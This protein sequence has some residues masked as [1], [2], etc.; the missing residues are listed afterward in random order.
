[1]ELKEGVM[2]RG[3][4]LEDIAIENILQEANR[5]IHGD[6]NKDYCHPL[7][8]YMATA[9]IWSGILNHKLKEPLTPEE[10]MLCMIGVKLSRESRRHKRDNLVD[11]AGYAGCIEMAIEERERRGL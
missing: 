5:L 7:D 1:M 10:T 2:E 9:M 3:G 8:D 6:R 4:T 11:A